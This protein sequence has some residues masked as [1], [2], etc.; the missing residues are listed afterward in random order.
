[1]DMINLLV[2]IALLIEVYQYDVDPKQPSKPYFPDYESS[3]QSSHPTYLSYEQLF[4]PYPQYGYY[5]PNLYTRRR[6]DDD[7]FEP[8]PHSTWNSLLYCMLLVKLLLYLK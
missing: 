7:D 4:Q 6:T 1:M 3:S 2:A 5:H 8:P